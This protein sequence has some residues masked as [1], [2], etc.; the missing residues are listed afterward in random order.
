MGRRILFLSTPEKIMRRLFLLLGYNF[1][2]L[3]SVLSSDKMKTRQWETIDI[4]FEISA[5]PDSPFLVELGCEFTSPDGREC[6]ILVDQCSGTNH[7]SLVIDEE[8]PHKI[9]HEDGTPYNLLA[10]EADWLFALDYGDQALPKTM[11]LLGTLKE[12]GFNQVVMNVYAYDV[13]WKKDPSLQDVHEY[14]GRT[15]IFPFLG[16]NEDPDHSSLNID[17]F[18]HLDRVIEWLRD[19]GIVSHLMI[20]VWNKKV[21]WPEPGSPEDNLYFDYVVKRYQGYTNILWDISKE[22]LGYGRD[23][24][25]YIS[26]RIERLRSLDGY[27]R[28]LTVHDYSYCSRYP[29][30]VNVISIQNWSNEIYNRMLEVRKRYPDKPVL[31]IEHG[32]YEVSP[33]EVFG[34]N[35]DN[36]EI[37][38][39]RNYLCAFA[40]TYATYY[41]QGTSWNVI[42][43]DPFSAETN[44][45][46]KFAYYKHF[47]DF[48]QK[49]PD[50]SLVPAFDRSASGYCLANRREDTFIYFVPKENRA[51]DIK[52]LPR[53]DRMDIT[54]FN[55]LSGRY[56]ETLSREWSA[57]FSLLPVFED[58]DNI[59]I[60]SLEE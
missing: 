11:Q 56:S 16:T 13:S 57:Y 15:D 33:Y 7:G 23:D 48:F 30:K 19:H 6:R 5:V 59:L 58:A 29:E 36:P 24:M 3:S 47:S 2:V 1:L 60:I 40:G 8:H 28:L 44:P 52:N 53:S 38:L 45:Q 22:A 50:E 49:Y 54:W 37:C 12:H 20:Y 39:R 43:H 9:R 32:G 31:N 26:E 41:W 25:G 51:I 17:F 55:P 34:G 35:Y 4:S 46:P 18:R 14:G 10:F 27:D 42:I 21:N